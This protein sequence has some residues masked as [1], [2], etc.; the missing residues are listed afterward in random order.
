[1]AKREYPDDDNRTIV[2]MNVEGFGWYESEEQKKSKQALAR[3][4]P[5]ERRSLARS[6]YLTVALPLVCLLVGM[7]VAFTVL[8]FL[9]L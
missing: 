5:K 7:L 2:N 9:W 3:K 4:S 6:A 8:Y 1:M